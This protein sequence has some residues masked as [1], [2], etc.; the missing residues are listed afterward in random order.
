[1]KNQTTIWK[2]MA[3]E[4]IVLSEVKSRSYP[5]KLNWNFVKP[6]LYW[7]FWVNEMDFFLKKKK[8]NEIDLKK[9]Q[10]FSQC[11]EMEPN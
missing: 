6:L 7:K 8:I 4:L 3:L 2:Q 1:M 5:T 11:D 10:Q 9:F